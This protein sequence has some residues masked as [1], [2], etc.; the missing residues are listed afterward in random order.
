MCIICGSKQ[1]ELSSDK[2]MIGLHSPLALS[3]PV[4]FA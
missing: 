1:Y 2:D 4:G 3:A